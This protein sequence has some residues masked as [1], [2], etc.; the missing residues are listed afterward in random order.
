ML[1]LILRVELLVAGIFIGYAASV[2]H[3]ALHLRSGR[4]VMRIPSVPARCAEP[5]VELVIPQA[6]ETYSHPQADT[7]LRQQHLWSPG[8]NS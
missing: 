2:V 4:K 7:V 3:G 5:R 6:R 8:G 1:G